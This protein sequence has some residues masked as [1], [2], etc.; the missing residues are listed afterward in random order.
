ME[1]PLRGAVRWY[2]GCR[3][4]QATPFY[5]DPERIRALAVA[6]DELAASIDTAVFRIF[7]TEPFGSDLLATSK[8]LGATARRLSP[9]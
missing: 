3:E 2:L 7:V 6:P 5:G 8:R 4:E 9:G 1:E